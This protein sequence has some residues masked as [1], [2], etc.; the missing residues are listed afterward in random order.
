MTPL[1]LD[2]KLRHYDINSKILS[3]YVVVGH[4]PCLRR[5]L[6]RALPPAAPAAGTLRAAI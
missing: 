3:N 6:R 5:R 4:G 2:K 1:F